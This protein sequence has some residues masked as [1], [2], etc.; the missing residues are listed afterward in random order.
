MALISPSICMYVYL[1]SESIRDRCSLNIDI[2]DHKGAA[3]K[4]GPKERSAI[5]SKIILMILIKFQ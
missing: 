2:L 3:L 5:L 1:C 4:M